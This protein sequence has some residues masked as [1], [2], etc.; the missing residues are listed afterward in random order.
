MIRKKGLSAKLAF[1][2]CSM[3]FVIFVIFISIVVLQTQSKLKKATVNELEAIA[4][5]NGQY[6]EQM[7]YS[8]LITQRDMEGYM[9]DADQTQNA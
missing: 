2:Q 7:V 8:A 9:I 4:Q 3:L 6:I 1:L 5:T